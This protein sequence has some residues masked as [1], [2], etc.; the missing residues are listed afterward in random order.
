MT[1]LA[2]MSRYCEVKYAEDFQHGNS[3]GVGPVGCTYLQRHT[4]FSRSVA[5]DVNLRSD[6]VR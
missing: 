3:S 5:F 4:L 2:S 1:C 6:E